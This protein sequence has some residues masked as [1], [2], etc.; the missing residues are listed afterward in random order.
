MY[1]GRNVFRRG[2]RVNISGRMN[3]GTFVA[4][5]VRIQKSS[6]FSIR[7]PEGSRLPAFCFDAKPSLSSRVYGGIIAG[8]DNDDKKEDRLSSVSPLNAAPSA[9][10]A[11]KSLRIGVLSAIGL[12]IRAT[13]ATPSPV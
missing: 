9:A 4:D 3:R 1:G 13:P 2:D 11:T 12:S 5:G 7:T 6:P 10:T 8:S